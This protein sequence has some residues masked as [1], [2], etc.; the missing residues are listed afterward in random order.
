LSQTPPWQGTRDAFG[1]GASCSRLQFASAKSVQVGMQHDDSVQ[2]P[3]VPQTI[4]AAPARSCL[5]LLPAQTCVR[6]AYDSHV[7]T[8]HASAQLPTLPWQT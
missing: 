2:L 7:S 8:Q 1:T 3:V 6:L 4:V 5:L